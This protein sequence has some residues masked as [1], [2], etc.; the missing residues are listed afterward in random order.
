[1]EHRRNFELNA[2]HER[3]EELAKKRSD[4]KAALATVKSTANEMDGACTTERGM[5][6]YFTNSSF[7]LMDPEDV[8]HLLLSK[9]KDVEEELAGLCINIQTRLNEE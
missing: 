8:E 3:L 7:F 1:M 2:D 4:L 5:L 9:L 6:T